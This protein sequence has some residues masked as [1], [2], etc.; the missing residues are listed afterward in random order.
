MSYER[1][2]QNN[3]LLTTLSDRASALKQV[4]I[5]IY[6]NAQ[7]SHSIIDRNDDMFSSMGTSLKNSAGRL[8]R[9]ARGNGRWGTV[10]LAGCIV[11]GV[12]VVYYLG[13]FIFSF[14]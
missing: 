9:M 2:R 5:N 14:F 12:V 10:R 3:A 6:D 1:E 8:G 11:A 13:S 7:S 4:T